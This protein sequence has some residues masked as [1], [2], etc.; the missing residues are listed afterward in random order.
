MLRVAAPFMAFRGLVMAHPVWYPNLS[1]N[2][3]RQ[4]FRFMRAVFREESFNPREVNRYCE[5]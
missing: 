4:L 3:R 5:A 1:M 2:V